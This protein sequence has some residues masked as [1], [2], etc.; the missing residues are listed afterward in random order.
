MDEED[1]PFARTVD[2][3]EPESLVDELRE[4]ADDA[5]ALARAEFAYQKSRASY[6]GKQALIIA[7]FGGAALVFL[8]FAVEALVFGAILTLAPHLTALVATAA[9]MGVLVAAA[10]LCAALAL[11]R[12]RRM[13]TKIA[14]RGD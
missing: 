7:G 14:E 4:L 2:A 9:V 10:L 8:F 1:L 5:Q 11:F 13:K 3:S 6:A 12:W